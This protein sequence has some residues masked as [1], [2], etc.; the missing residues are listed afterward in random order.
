[1]TAV[2]WVNLGHKD[3]HTVGR[4]CEDTQGEDKPCD[5]SDTYMSQ[6]M[7]RIAGNHQKLEE[8]RKYHRQSLQRK[9]GPA[10]ALILD[11]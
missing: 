2:I 1:M 4:Q 6:G 11:F 7:L 5:C 10:N 8:S 3:R 9:H